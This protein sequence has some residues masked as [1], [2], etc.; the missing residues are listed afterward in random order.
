MRLTRGFGMGVVV[1]IAIA[2]LASASYAAAPGEGKEL[3]ASPFS[4]PPETPWVSAGSL[5]ANE[6]AVFT[7]EGMSAARARQALALQGEVEEARLPLRIEAA[8]GDAYAGVWFDPPAGKFDVG[9]TSTASAWSVRRIAARANLAGEVVEMP[10][11]STMGALIEA[12]EE[13]NK[14]LASL[15]ASGEATTAIDP[16]RN[17]VVITL[18]SA[19]ASHESTAL[20][21]EATDANVNVVVSITALPS[22]RREPRNVTCESP[23]TSGKARCEKTLVSGVGIKVES[24]PSGAVFGCTAGPLLL[25]GSETYMTS[26]GH[27]F[28]SNTA[29]GTGTLRSNSTGKVTSEWQGTSGQKEIGKEDAYYWNE[30]GDMSETR[31]AAASPFLQGGNIPISPLMAEWS[32]KPA[33]PSAVSRAVAPVMNAAVCREG[34]TSGEQCG[35]IT[36]ESVGPAPFQVETNAC[37][38]S[39]DSGGPFVFG[40]LTSKSPV[41][42]EGILSSGNTNCPKNATTKTWFQPLLSVRRA[43]GIEPTFHHAL[44]NSNNQDRNRAIPNVHL[45]TLPTSRA[46]TV[47]VVYDELSNS[48]VRVTCSNGL[49]EGEATSTETV[50]KMVIVYDSCMG[51]KGTEKS[52]EE[53]TVKSAGAKSEGEVVTKTL[54]GELGEVASSE[55]YTEGGLLLEPETGKTIT[56]LTGKCLGSSTG[57]AGSLAAEVLPAE[58]STKVIEDNFAATSGKQLIKTISVKAGNVKPKLELGGSEA[59]EQEYLEMEFAD[60]VEL[61]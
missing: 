32:V 28:S 13:W 15:L 60:E 33:T 50:G 14:R 34:M 61:V 57:L 4:S 18:G 46:I 30:L 11:R 2:V 31:I 25:N 55:A 40:S 5:V 48:S 42:M 6:E 19:I 23:F 8:L 43:N 36:A 54:K 52:E 7:H 45:H 9:V 58:V 1:L 38:L 35:Q 44:L 21:H 59:V 20:Q 22:L 56:E 3:F 51:E 47:A 16:S 24:A 53:C 12:K 27:C 26:A 39:G 49:G 37:S 17:A 29:K 41:E 10:V